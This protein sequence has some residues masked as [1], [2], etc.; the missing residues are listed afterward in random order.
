[1]VLRADIV[2][3]GVKTFFLGID[4]TMFEKTGGVDVSW[5]HF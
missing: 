5:K 4:A 2:N 3:K 1:M